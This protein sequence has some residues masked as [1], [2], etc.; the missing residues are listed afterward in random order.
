ARASAPAAASDLVE[1]DEELR[2][3]EAALH[4]TAE[5][6]GGVVLF[7]GTAGIG[8]TRLLAELRD[9]ARQRDMLVL[10]ARAGLLEREYAF[11]VVRQLLEDAVGA[12]RRGGAAAAAR[13]VLGEEGT[14]EGPFPILN[15]LVALVDQLADPRPAVLCVDDL[16]W[17]DPASLR[18][19][20]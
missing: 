13:V 18:F 19:V 7:E 17:S 16:Q 15:G 20:S 6:A 14:S 5:G 4:R 12:S 2:A 8:K 9:R 3:V 1:R 11:G 10:E